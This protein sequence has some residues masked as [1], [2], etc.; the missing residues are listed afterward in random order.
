M[1]GSATC[2]ESAGIGFISGRLAHAQMRLQTVSK[3]IIGAKQLL[4][5]SRSP[6]PFLNT[7]IAV[8]L[9]LC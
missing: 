8:S 2:R 1:R 4:E 6:H 5:E 9:K 7:L 3:R